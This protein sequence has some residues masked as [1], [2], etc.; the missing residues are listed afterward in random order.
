VSNVDLCEILVR[1]Y[2]NIPISTRDVGQDGASGIPWVHTLGIGYICG[3]LARKYVDL[4]VSKRD[5]RRDGA[6]GGRCRLGLLGYLVDRIESGDI[7]MYKCACKY[8]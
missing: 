2:L 7:Y 6:G 1:K 8:T 5:V 4:P 3:N